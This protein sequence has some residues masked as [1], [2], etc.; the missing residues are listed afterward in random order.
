MPTEKPAA[1]PAEN[2]A[3][4]PPET[5]SGEPARVGAVDIEVFAHNLAR[6]IE[7]GGKALAARG[8]QNQTGYG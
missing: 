1:E 8:R 2:Q 4:K 3:K 5:P 6:M 7:E